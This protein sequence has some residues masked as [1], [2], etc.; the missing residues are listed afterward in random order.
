MFA[1][2]GTQPNDRAR[3][4]LTQVA[5]TLRRLPNRIAITG[6]TST[7]AAGRRDPWM[8]WELSMGRAGAV[9]EILAAAGLPNDRFAVVAGKAD[10]DPLFPDNPYLA[11][12]RRVTITLLFEAPALPAGLKP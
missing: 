8:Q 2:G 5:A 10:T 12:N 1:E 7:T 6:H 11:A 3:Q 4:V 9:R